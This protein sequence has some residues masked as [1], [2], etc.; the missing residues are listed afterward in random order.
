MVKKKPDS[1]GFITNETRSTLRKEFYEAAHSVPLRS[2]LLVLL[3]AALS[4]EASAVK[5]NWDLHRGG[6]EDAEEKSL[7]LKTLLARVSVVKRLS[8]LHTAGR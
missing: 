7:K 8:D 1:L 5:K 2:V 3:V 6:A 4:R